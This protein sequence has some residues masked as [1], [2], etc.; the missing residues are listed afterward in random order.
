MLRRGNQSG[1]PGQSVAHRERPTGQEPRRESI[2]Q[3]EAGVKQGQCPLRLVVGALSRDAVMA[4]I[5]P[6]CIQER[7]AWWL[8]VGECAMTAMGE[9]TLA[10]AHILD[11]K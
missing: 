7:C 4:R 1:T 8:E 6:A 5:M 3:I 11:T 10:I 9:G 2:P